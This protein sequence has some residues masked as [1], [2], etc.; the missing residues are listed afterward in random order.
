MSRSNTAPTSQAAF[1][2]ALYAMFFGSGA[3]SLMCQVLWFKQLQFVL[4][5]STFAV[6]V[7]VAS[8][9]CGL[10]VGSFL[11]GRLADRL[12]RPMRGYGLLELALAGVSL[13]ITL[14]LTNWQ[15]WALWLSD[16]LGAESPWNRP[17]T[18]ALAFAT[19][20]PP[21]LLMGATLPVLARYVVREQ[22]QLAVEIGILYGVNTLGAAFGCAIV[23][24]YL[25]GVFGVF[26]TALVASAV[27]LAIGAAGL[28]L[29]TADRGAEGADRPEPPADRA[30]A[31]ESPAGA[32]PTASSSADGVW[33]LVLVFG[34]SGFLSIAYEVVWFRVLANAGMHTVYAFSAMLTTYLLGLVLG[35]F[36]CARF[37]ASRKDRL[38]RY[39]AEIQLAIAIGGVLSLVLLGRLDFAARFTALI[40]QSGL[41]TSWLAAA[42]DVEG[43]VPYY[44]LVLLVPT[45]LIGIGFPLASELT[46]HRLSGL[47]RRLGGLYAL[48]TLGGV[49]GSLVTGFVL[50]NYLGSQ[51]TLSLLIFANIALFVAI[52]ATQRQLTREW[53]LWREGAATLLVV[54]LVVVWIGPDYLRRSQTRYLFGEPVAFE[55]SQHGTVLVMSYKSPTSGDHQQL[56]FNGRSYANN[57]PP[58]RRYMAALAHIPLLLHPDPKRALVVCV[59]T[60]TTIGATTKHGL[61]ESEAVDLLPQAFQYAPHFT[62]INQRFFEHPKVRKTVDDGR[63]FLLTTSRTFD[64]LTFEPPPPLDAGIVNLYSEE[65]YALAKRKMRPGGLVAQ[66]VPMDMPRAMMPK[67]VLK[68]M[69]NQFPHVSLWIS[70]RMEGIAVGSETPLAIDYDQLAERMSRPELKADLHEVGIDSPE[71]FLAMFVAADEQLAK[72]VGDAPSVTDDRPRIEYYNLYE[73]KALRFDDVLPF[74]ESIDRY[75]VGAGRPNPARL[76]AAKQA[77][78]AIFFE[79][80]ARNAL[81]EA[82]AAQHAPAE[83]EWLAKTQS[84]IQS[85][86]EGEPENVYL[87]YLRDSLPEQIEQAKP[88]HAVLSTTER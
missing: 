3:A 21:T 47:G 76:E 15:V 87:K 63:H 26:G 14:I 69:L 33:A 5:S 71:D 7:T 30:A 85:G 72:L 25:I 68:S 84:L 60:G 27:Y 55:E 48:N 12:A 73:S 66:W 31:V 58:G 2:V 56:F 80:E 65:F 19:L 20:L 82:V 38:V 79:H 51:Q 50:L 57:S 35:S 4:G 88:E 78:D 43:L 1:K 62:P 61:E 13:L 64:V 29:S 59:G 39:F 37:L 46:I 6:S 70:N 45:T 42:G 49:L 86:L 28:V 36:L 53:V 52:V 75:L 44:C 9:F 11:G 83:A 8:F 40:R 22:R 41:P 16:S 81:L 23:G 10:A 67:M 74:R 18:I 32:A 17:I 24:Y 34:A 77:T 54:A